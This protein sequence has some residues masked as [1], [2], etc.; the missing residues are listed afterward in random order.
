MT[1]GRSMGIAMAAVWLASPCF[2]QTDPRLDQLEKQLRDVQQQL[3]QIKR[4]PRDDSL[5]DLKRS[6]AAQ[7]A[8]LEKRIAARPK[9]GLDNGRLSFVSADGDFS[10]ALRALVQF[11]LGYFGQGKNPPSVD[12]NSGTNFRRAQF[13]FFGTVWRDWSY[14][15]VYDFGGRGVEKRGYIYAGYIEY[16][17]LKPLG[18]RIG[19]F[20]PPGGLDDST[21]GADLAFLERS[22]SADVAS[23]IAGAPGREGAGIFAQGE[24]YFLSATWTGK[25]NIDAATFDAQQA[26][27]TRAAWLAVDDGAVKWLLDA[28]FT[29]VFKV[30]DTVPGSNGVYELSSEPE[31]TVDGSRTVDTGAVDARGVNQWG[32]ETALNDGPFHAQGGYFQIEIQ[33]RTALPNPDFSGWYAFA[34][35]SLTGESH[36]YDPATAVFRGLKPAHPLGTPGGWGAWELKARYSNI[37]LESRPLLAGGVAGGVQNIWT[38]GMNWFPTYGLRFALDYS[39]IG[40]THTGAPANDISAN[41]IALRS[42]LA[43]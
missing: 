27:V 9:V 40:V 1:S 28:D 20:S 24:R 29:R 30:A 13:G 37:D 7:H 22:A 42:Q 43:L 4:K 10:V 38:V 18:F 36:V 39:N 19:A 32:V 34:T 2:A 12:L 23:G 21:P 11:D 8:D 41:A 3:A 6:T 16:D 5:A 35:W 33:R 25:R 31:L 26:I 14:T 15:F 17:G